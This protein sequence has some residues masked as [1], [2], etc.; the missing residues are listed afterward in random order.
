MTES[1][2]ARY[3]LGSDE[4]EL[5]RLELQGRA[6]AP[7]TRSILVEAGIQAGMHVLDLGC[8]AGDVTFVAAELVGTAGSVIGLDRSTEA[9]ARARLRADQR[10]L[11]NVEFHDGDIYEPAPG[12]PFDAITGRLILMYVP[13][14]AVVL[15]EQATV[16][17][18]GGLLIPI[19]P[20]V[21]TAQ[22]FPPTPLVRQASS[23]VAEAFRRSGI[24]TSLGRQLWTVLIEAGLR[25]L[26]MTGS[27][28][29]F[30]PTDPDGAALLSGVVRT[31]MPLMERT[32]LATADDVN[33][34]TLFERLSSELVANG[35]VFAHPMLLSAWGT[36]E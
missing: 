17:R 1:T 19:E 12:G 5:A 29:H 34:E 30:G 2:K 9:L 8:G 3:E 10:G 22:A 6:L 26:G 16:L 24:H 36:N 32:G 23:W 28:P 14:P 35:A 25:P 20:D 7:A 15:K 27:Q 11:T 33:P 13:D 18:A 31:V 21:T 4:S